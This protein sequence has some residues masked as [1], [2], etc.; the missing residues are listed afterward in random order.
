MSEAE[1][2]LRELWTRKGVSEARQNGLVAAV[3]AKGQLGAQLI[4]LP[5]RPEACKDEVADILEGV[6][7][8][9]HRA[10]NGSDRTIGDLKSTIRAARHM[11]K[12]ALELLYQAK[13][14]V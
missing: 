2:E 7:E 3:T 4:L 1:R 6:V 5:P 12:N 13:E 10:A 14:R 9:L 11:A 8:M